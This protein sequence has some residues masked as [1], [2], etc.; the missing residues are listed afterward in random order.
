MVAAATPPASPLL[1]TPPPPPSLAVIALPDP[2]LGWWENALVFC[3][4]AVLVPIP[5]PPET[6]VPAVAAVAVA[7]A[8]TAA[9]AAAAAK[10]A[11]PSICWRNVTAKRHGTVQSRKGL[12]MYARPALKQKRAK[13]HVELQAKK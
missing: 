10:L 1:P 13:P 12:K 5:L 9:T 3:L 7:A 2:P 4:A 6:L 11:L 8:A